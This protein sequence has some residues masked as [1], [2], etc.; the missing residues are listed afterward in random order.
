MQCVSETNQEALAKTW[1][2]LVVRFGR[3]GVD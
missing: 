2:C 1:D 3:G